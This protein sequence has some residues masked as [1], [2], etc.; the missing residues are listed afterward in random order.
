M[1]KLQEEMGY[2]IFFLITYHES[3]HDRAGVQGKK[4][5]VQ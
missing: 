1:Q 4:I 3:Y 2:K 5:W